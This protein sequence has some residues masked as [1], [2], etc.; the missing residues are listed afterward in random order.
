MKKII[1]VLFA[2]VMLSGC[3]TFNEAMLRKV[4]IPKQQNPELIVETK[5]G[6][7]VQKFNGTPNRGVMSGTTVLNA[8][9]KSMM[10]R[11]KKKGLIADFGAAGKLDKKPDFTL[12]VSG[13][14]DEEGSVLGAVLC[15]ITL[16]IIPTSSTLIYDLDVELVNNKT[17]QHYFVKVKNGVT[18]WMEIIFLPFF[19]ISWIGSRNMSVDMADY[20]YDELRQQRAFNG[21]GQQKG[22]QTRPAESTPSET[23]RSEKPITSAPTTFPLGGFQGEQGDCRDSIFSIEEAWVGNC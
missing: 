6:D 1:L 12:I 11:W 4:D 8:V 17:Q 16:S 18:T 20:A 14:R 3:M 5:T 9:V 23:T 21:G 15:G 7:L 19:A 2:M 22:P 10:N 13:V